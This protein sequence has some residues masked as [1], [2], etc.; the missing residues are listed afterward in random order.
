MP[1]VKA[2]RNFSIALTSDGSVWAWGENDEGQLGN[3]TKESI[4]KPAKVAALSD[5]AAVEAG[6]YHTLAL[7]KDETVWAWGDNSHGQEAMH[8]DRKIYCAICT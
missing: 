6:E 7:K 1:M 2:G 5:I 4:T 8:T 3:G